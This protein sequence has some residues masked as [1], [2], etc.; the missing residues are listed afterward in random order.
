M[1]IAAEEY[2][3]LGLGWFKVYEEFSRKAPWTRIALQFWIQFRSMGVLREMG[4]S[5]RITHQPLPC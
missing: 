3:S 1:P 2:L 5:W 4:V